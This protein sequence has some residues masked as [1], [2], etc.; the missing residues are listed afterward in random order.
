MVSIGE[1]N[2]SA[3][4]LQI[5]DNLYNQEV[6]VPTDKGSIKDDR[7]TIDQLNN[8]EDCVTLLSLT[9]F[10]LVTGIDTKTVLFYHSYFTGID[11]FSVYLQTEKIDSASYC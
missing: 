8:P 6:C 4:A 5:R 2:G 10:F 3:D 11:W 1:N 9:R 7:F